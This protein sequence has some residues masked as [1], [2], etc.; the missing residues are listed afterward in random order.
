[1]TKDKYGVFEAL[2]P[3]FKVVLKG[4]RGL[5]DGKHLEW[6]E[7]HSSNLVYFP[8][9]PRDEEGNQTETISNGRTARISLPRS[10]RRDP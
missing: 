3:F 6:T 2:N 7:T 10:S 9:W 1:M 8:G 5:V 4:L